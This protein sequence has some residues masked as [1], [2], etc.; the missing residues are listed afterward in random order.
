MWHV[1]LMQAFHGGLHFTM[2]VQS[3]QGVCKPN[4]CL[5]RLKNIALHCEEV[6]KEWT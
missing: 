2:C 5:W 6:E 1:A 3:H 4:V